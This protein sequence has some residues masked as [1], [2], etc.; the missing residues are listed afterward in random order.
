MLLTAMGTIPEYLV[1]HFVAE[2]C[3]AVDF[4]HKHRIVHRDIKVDNLLLTA[5]GH[6]KL[7]DFG[8]FNYLP[9][10]SHHPTQTMSYP[11][12][13]SSD[14]DLG[15]FRPYD[16]DIGLLYTIVGNT[17]YQAPEMLSGTGYD[18]GADW[19]AVGILTFHL[20]SAVTPFE[21]PDDMDNT[22]TNIL[23]DQANVAALPP[24]LSYDSVA[25]ISELLVFD[26]YQRMGGYR[27]WKQ[28]LQHKFFNG[29]DLN[30]IHSRPGPFL[31]QMNPGLCKWIKSYSN[32]R[33]HRLD[34]LI[35]NVNR[36]LGNAYN[37]GAFRTPLD[38]RC[39]ETFSYVCTD[40]PIR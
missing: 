8:L 4:L 38:D 23:L 18:E 15:T 7:S 6:V 12:M 29:I 17:C 1:R 32:A 30:S 21:D 26:R 20:L 9:S 2:T 28:A 33:L 11:G 13:M 10:R 36:G 22:V 14:G 19:W 5:S 37:S 40:F 34:A 25:F 24:G 39:F 31:P 3:M 27:N 16:R 35:P